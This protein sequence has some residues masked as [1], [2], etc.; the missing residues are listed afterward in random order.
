M[1]KILISIISFILIFPLAFSVIGCK[2]EEQ[3]NI[4]TDYYKLSYYDSCDEE[5]GYNKSLFYQNDTNKVGP[6]PSVVYGKGSDGNNYYYVFPTGNMRSIYGYR[7]TNLADWSGAGL[8]FVPET[9]SWAQT[10]MWAPDV[11]YDAEAD[12]G[13]GGKGLYYLFF[14]AA[15]SVRTA[16][17]NMYFDSRAERRTFWTI[18]DQ[19][20]SLTD[21]QA[22]S[23]LAYSNFNS[24]VQELCATYGVTNNG[25]EVTLALATYN[26]NKTTEE[27][28]SDISSAQIKKNVGEFARQAILEIRISDMH[29]VGYNSQGSY[30]GIVATAK[31]LDGP[32]IQ[33]TND[34]TNGERPISIQEPFLTHEDLYATLSQKYSIDKCLNIVDMHPFIDPVTGD[35]YMYFNSNPLAPHQI[36][37]VAEIFVV[38]VGDKNARWTDDWQWNTVKQLTRTG[39][40]DMGVNENHKKSDPQTDLGESAINEGA[41]VIYNETNGKYYLTISKGNWDSSNYAIVQAVGDSPMGPFTKFSRA[42]GGLLLQ[43]ETNWKHTVGPGHHSFIKV[44]GKTYI[45]YHKHVFE[46]ASGDRAIAIDEIKWTTNG[47]GEQIMYCNGPSVTPQPKMDSGYKN[48]IDKGTIT[49]DNGA[50]NKASLTDGLVNATSELGFVKEFSAKAGTTTISIDFN[51]YRTVRAIMIYNSR[52]YKKAFKSIRRI[53]MDFAGV[54][55]GTQVKGTAYIDNLKFNENYFYEMYGQDCVIPASAAIA[56]FD[57]LFVKSIRIV[58]DKA[59]NVSEIVILGK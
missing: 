24:K 17:G 37:S 32:F 15:D 7:S 1:R 52:E 5:L 19:V 35:K 21:D 26:A 23:A 31:T 9:T 59:V 38:K 39:H 11:I 2:Q 30:A 56:E 6:D 13:Q 29:K 51:A 47:N 44:D 46:D 12:D 4:K 10:V 48:I 55:N 45:V 36:N 18:K 43:T 54:K 49:V 57:E 14:T 20:N 3:P 28:R 33:Y 22:I 34:G 16:E 53:E 27:K 50:S 25:G 40:Y 58:L 8:V 41:Y 42:Q